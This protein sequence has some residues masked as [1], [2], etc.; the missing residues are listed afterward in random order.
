[1]IGPIKTVG[2]YVQDQKASLEFYTQKLGFELRREIQMAPETSWLEVAPP[3]AQ[4]CFVLYP[5]AMMP[6]WEHLKP[7][8][9]FQSDDVEAACQQLESR[10][11]T[12]TMQPT[13]M[14][15]GTFAKFVD[16]DGN[17]FGLTAQTL[18]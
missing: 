4:T 10:G 2:I 15:W 13:P 14:G 17:E 6:N 16:P 3:G 9:V 5:K 11:V 18:A 8:V 1:M 7:S 12:I